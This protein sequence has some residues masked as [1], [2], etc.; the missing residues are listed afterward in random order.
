[1]STTKQNLGRGAL[2]GL[3]AAT[4]LALWFFAIDLIRDRPLFTPAFMISTLLGHKAVTTD[5]M[6]IATYTV[7]HFASFVLV[8]I[9]VAWVLERTGIQ[10]HILL[11]LVLGFL[12]FDLV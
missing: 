2:A 7:I 11:G 3:L 5:L 1:M 10:P 6:L 12:L 8:G 4:V 9:V